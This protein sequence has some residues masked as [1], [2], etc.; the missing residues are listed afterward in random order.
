MLYEAGQRVSQRRG[1]HTAQHPWEPG[2]LMT[3]GPSSEVQ[4][5]GWVEKEQRE[6]C[7]GLGRAEGYKAHQALVN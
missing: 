5:G 1:L 2:V 4:Q 6:L 3:T 7:C